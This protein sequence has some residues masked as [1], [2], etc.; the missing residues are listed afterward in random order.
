ME[1]EAD[2]HVGLRGLEGVLRQLDSLQ[3][4]YCQ[5]WPYDDPAGRLAERVGARPRRAQ[6]SGIGGSVPLQGEKCRA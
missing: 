5:S 2:P 4:V 6:Y 1:V 3:V